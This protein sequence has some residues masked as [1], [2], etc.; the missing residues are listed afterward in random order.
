MTTANFSPDTIL[1]FWFDEI[2]KESWFRKDPDFD[3]MIRDRFLE[4]FL[5]AAACELASWRQ[6]FLGRLAEIIVL[7][8]FSRNLL[9][10]SAEAF[11]Q[12]SLALA[13]SQEAVSMGVLDALEPARQAFLII[14]FMHSES[15]LIHEQALELFLRPGLEFNLDFEKR[16]KE[17]IDRFGRYPHRNALLGR[18]STPEELAFLQQPGSSF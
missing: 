7:D 9:R 18:V 14:P 15:S 12:D 4:V 2:S 1:S 16:H 6:T 17:I 13:L 8:Q 3:A 5:S 10:E 11:A